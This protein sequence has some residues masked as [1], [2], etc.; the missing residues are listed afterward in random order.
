MTTRSPRSFN[1]RRIE[2]SCWLLDGDEL[3]TEVGNHSKMTTQR[4]DICADR[5][6][7]GMAEVAAFELRDSRLRDGHRSGQLLLGE[8]LRKPQFHEAMGANLVEQLTLSLRD[9]GLAHAAGRNRGT[10][11]VAP[12]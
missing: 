5:P 1:D 2:R 6:E 11:H 4:L 8:V 7:L 10:T 3:I 9:P 12:L